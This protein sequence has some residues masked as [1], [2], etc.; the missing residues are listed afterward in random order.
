MGPIW[1][2]KGVNHRCSLRQSICET[3]L[4]FM[5]CFRAPPRKV[6]DSSHLRS[7]FELM[8]VF[9]LAAVLGVLL[10]VDVVIL[11]SNR[12]GPTDGDI[13]L[14]P[15]SR[16]EFAYT[17]SGLPA[18]SRGADSWHHIFWKG[19]LEHELA[20]AMRRPASVTTMNLMK[21]MN[22]NCSLSN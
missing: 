15:H 14:P 9:G 2:Q 11:C 16:N 18:T 4:A 22:T 19:V 8:L 13:G 6:S 17:A 5:I 1:E 20:M 3:L 7:S 21:A 12:V 10:Y